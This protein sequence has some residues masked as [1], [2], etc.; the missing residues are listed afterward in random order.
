MSTFGKKKRPRGT[1]YWKMPSSS[2]SPTP[3]PAEMSPPAPA[4]V[5]TPAPAEMTTPA[6]VEVSTPVPA[7][8]PTPIQTSISASWCLDS[9][10]SSCLTPVTPKIVNA[11]SV[12]AMRSIGQGQSSMQTFFTKM[13][14][15][16]P[17]WPSA[18]NLHNKAMSDASEKTALENML[19]ASVYLHALHGAEPTEV[20]DIAVT[21]DGTW[22]KRG[23]TAV[24]CCRCH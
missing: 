19:A 14:M 2:S 1:Q 8:V 4:E 7:E 21:C 12:L 22:S 18:F 5:S 10:R 24:W 23:F 15:L 11:R 17:V 13:D 16:P 20:V 9:T 3:A 6:Q